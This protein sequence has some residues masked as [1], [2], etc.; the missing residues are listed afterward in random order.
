MLLGLLA[1]VL[2]PARPAYAQSGEPGKI[3][4]GDNY[5]LA[6]GETL[7]GDLVVFGGNVTIEES[8]D[9]DGNL[10]V[11]GGTISSNGNVNGDVVIFGGQIELDEQAVVTG[12]IVTIG[13]QV[14]QAEGARVQGD[15]LNNVAP[16]FRNPSGRI[17]PEIPNIAIPNG[18]RFG[19]PNPLQ[20]LS[21]VFVW[22]VALAA[23]AMLLTLFWQ[24]QIE[25]TGKMIVAQPVQIGAVGLLAFILCLFLILTIIPPLILAFAWLFGL[26]A[27]GT[28]VG[29][30]FSKAVSQT[31]SPMQKTGFGT[32]TLVMVGGLIGSIPCLGPLVQFLLGLLGSGG[33]LMT[34]FGNRTALGSLLSS[35]PSSAT[36][37]QLPPAS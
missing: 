1:L 7:E 9:L 33:A 30:R 35:Q 28:E 14:E 17:P 24:P 8:A 4:F 22:A 34:W 19:F 37:D 2:V 15:V 23:F 5:I 21:M 12:D 25:K 31:W 3:I 27:M 11:F 10:V 6:T 36:P 32:F 20:D 29:E 16:D 26:I 18:V 13:G